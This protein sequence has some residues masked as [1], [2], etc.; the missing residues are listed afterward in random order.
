MLSMDQVA[1]GE[2]KPKIRTEY[3]GPS[4][5]R[6]AGVSPA[7]LRGAYREE[8]HRR[9]AG[10]TMAVR[11]WRRFGVNRRWDSSSIL[12]GW[13]QND[14]A[15]MGRSRKPMWS[16]AVHRRFF[17]RA[18]AHDTAET[19]SRWF[20]RGCPWAQSGS[21]LPHSTWRSA[22]WRGCSWRGARSSEIMLRTRENSHLAPR[23]WPT[24]SGPKQTVACSCCA[25]A[26]NPAL[27]APSF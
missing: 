18:F 2:W 17:A 10:A 8:K 6:S 7:N 23:Y 12:T 1:N 4:L 19:R 27:I 26:A 24:L 13:P 14:A 5:V 15:V 22:K 21:K 11:G 20:A 3:E 16:A 25:I 9:D